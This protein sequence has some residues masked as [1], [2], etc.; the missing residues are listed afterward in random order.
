MYHRVAAVD[1]DPWEMC[2]TPEHFAQHLDV[3]QQY[4]HPISLTQ[5]AQLH[6]S[7]QIPD[8]SVVITFD[9]GYADNYYNAKPLLEQKGIPATTFITTGTLGSPREFWWD[10]LEQVF[11][12]VGKLPEKLQL[13]LPTQCYEWELGSAAQ[14]DHN[15]YQ[16][17]RDR[18]VWNAPLGS[19]MALYYS[20][21]TQL[22]PLA[23]S[24]RQAVQNEIFRWAN[25]EAI[26][27]PGYC[28]LTVQE[29]LHLNQGNCIEIGAHTVNHPLFSSQSI[30][31]QHQEI[32][33][34][35]V[36]LERLIGQPVRTFAYPFGDYT[37][38][39]PSLV[40]ASGFDCACSIVKET[41]WRNSDCFQFPR[42]G[43]QNLNREAFTEWLLGAFDA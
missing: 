19:R 27:R 3:L 21:C 24:I 41:V 13:N 20:V 33:Q 36:E 34:S 17:D 37:A 10:E 28:P 16:Q 35:K 38:D 26:S 11:F 39:T 30:E 6:R 22:Q 5:L 42:F 18:C 2:V 14:Y 1:L 4:A 31:V 7:G 9:D 32:Q 43:V 40:K 29:L 25:L 15:E 8:R 23:P 12:R